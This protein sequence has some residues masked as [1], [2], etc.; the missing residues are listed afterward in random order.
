MKSWYPAAGERWVF[1]VEVQS[2]RQ[3]RKKILVRYRPVYMQQRAALRELDENLFLA[4]FYPE[5]GPKHRPLTGSRWLLLVEVIAFDGGKMSVGYRHIKPSGEP[6]SETKQMGTH[7]FRANFRREVQDGGLIPIHP[8]WEKERREWRA[9]QRQP[10]QG[11]WY[12]LDVKIISLRQE[13]G[14]RFVKYVP[15]ETEQF[16]APRELDEGV[17]RRLF[18]PADGAV[19]ECTPRDHWFMMV[20]VTDYDPEEFAVWYRPISSGG[21]TK[22]EIKRLSDYVFLATF[23]PAK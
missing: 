10:A 9:S 22:G 12:I 19:E 21:E 20:E 13:N 18:E 3:E 15:D 14:R 4:V 11:E 5:Q 2:I 8:E 16:A 23:R 7:V 17:F 1:H 6:I